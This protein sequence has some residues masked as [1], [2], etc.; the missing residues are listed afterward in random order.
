MAPDGRFVALGASFGG[1]EA[2]F[3]D[4][5]GVP[6][7]SEFFVADHRAG[8]QGESGFALG[9]AGSFVVAWT[10]SSYFNYGG[11]QRDGSGSGVF[12]RRFCDTNDASCDICPGYDDSIDEDADGIPNG[13]DPCTA[14]FA[15]QELQ[16]SKL[17]VRYG[18]YGIHEDLRA[19]DASTFSPRAAYHAPFDPLTSN[20][21][22]LLGD[23]DLASTGNSF[24]SLEPGTRGAR[25]RIEDADGRSVIDQTIPPGTFGGSGTRGWTSERDGRIWRFRDRT[26][27]PDN[28]LRTLILEDLDALAP[29]MARVVVRSKSGV[30]DFYSTPLALRA[31]V[32]FGDQDDADRSACTATSYASTDCRTRD[33]INASSA[34]CRN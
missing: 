34:S 22:R 31:I 23:F 19:G 20:R 8:F 11:S 26:E 29:G 4:A 16:D 25:L 6:E 5:S 24:A 33:V 21:V 18:I 3:F 2:R 14:A 15:G 27:A 10:D 32:V 1:I 9:S 13:C 28:G 7:G 17:D 30:Y 12:A